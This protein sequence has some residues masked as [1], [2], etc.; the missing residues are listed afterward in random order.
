L[1]TLRGRNPIDVPLFD[2]AK[3]VLHNDVRGV[4]GIAKLQEFDL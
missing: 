3:N 1:P 2:P 4:Q